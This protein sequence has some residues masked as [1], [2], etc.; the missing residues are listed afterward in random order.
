[1]MK[2]ERG[3]VRTGDYNAYQVGCF[4]GYKGDVEYE[5]S[6]R[7]CSEFDEVLSHG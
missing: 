7:V 3:D 1:M 4:L 2:A 5:D 6:S